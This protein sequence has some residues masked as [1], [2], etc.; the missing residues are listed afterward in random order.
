MTVHCS[1]SS[2][3]YCLGGWRDGTGFCFVFM[4][5]RPSGLSRSGVELGDDDILNRAV[6]FFFY[7]L[8]Y[9]G[10]R[11]C[12]SFEVALSITRM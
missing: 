9:F 3:S 1:F 6:F 2:A 7:F 12:G 11:L 8:G 5:L 4:D 10:R